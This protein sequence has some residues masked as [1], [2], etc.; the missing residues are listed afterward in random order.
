MFLWNLRQNFWWRGAIVC[1]AAV[2]GSS[3]SF[4]T[5][6]RLLDSRPVS[7]YI[8]LLV[9]CLNVGRD[10]LQRMLCTFQRV[11]KRKCR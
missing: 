3:P 6:I 9:I 4:G 5:V 1:V 8:V 10:Y 7:T 2:L 11:T